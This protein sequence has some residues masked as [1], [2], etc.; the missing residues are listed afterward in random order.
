MLRQ[1]ECSLGTVFPAPQGATVGEWAVS[2]VLPLGKRVIPGPWQ[3]NT[4]EE[5][6]SFGV[7]WVW[8]P[9]HLQ[10]ALLANLLIALLFLDTS[11]AKAFC[12]SASCNAWEVAEVLFF[13]S[14]SQPNWRFK[15]YPCTL[16]ILIIIPM[17]KQTRFK[18]NF[19]KMNHHLSESKMLFPSISFVFVAHGTVSRER[20]VHLAVIIYIAFSG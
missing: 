6:S 4:L 5:A 3:K 16:Q 7:V 19:P 12:C 18:G 2:W 10:E 1:T 11:F 8:S 15:Y 14:P 20:P 9:Q 13:T 17:V